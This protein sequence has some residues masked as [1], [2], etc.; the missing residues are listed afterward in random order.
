MAGPDNLGSLWHPNLIEQFDDIPAETRL[1]I[2]I[3][4]GDLSFFIKSQ[5]QLYGAINSL[6][7]VVNS[8]VF[9]D[10]LRLALNHAYQNA[11]ASQQSFAASSNALIER[12]VSAG[13]E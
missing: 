8:V 5:W 7:Q 2:A 9:T 11:Q 10:E 3:T 13:H 6:F 12:V 1:N 4:K